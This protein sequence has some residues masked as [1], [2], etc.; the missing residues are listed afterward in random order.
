MDVIEAIP[1]T[2]QRIGVSVWNAPNPEVNLSWFVDEPTLGRQMANPVL[3]EI[4]GMGAL[5]DH[6]TR[7]YDEVS[8]ICGI[9]IDVRA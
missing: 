7:P 4:E 8:G 6:A 1:R 9:T 3:L 5:H 2:A